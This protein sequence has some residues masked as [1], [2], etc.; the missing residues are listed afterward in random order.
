MNCLLRLA[1]CGV[2]LAIVFSGTPILAQDAAVIKELSRLEDAWLAAAAKKDGAAVGRL[3]APNFLSMDSQ[4][5]KVVDKATLIKDVSSS[6][7]NFVSVTGSNYKAQVS[8]NTAIIIG[9][10]TNVIK[11]ANGNET[12]RY[13]WTDTWMKQADGQW[14]CIA[15][16]A[17]RLPK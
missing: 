4:V 14:L 6:T 16:Q 12:F 9:I 2:V 17:T 7:E 5:G 3:I 10:T 15:S 13:A 1:A 8:G 11:R